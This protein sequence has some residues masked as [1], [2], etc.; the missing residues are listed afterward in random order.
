MVIDFSWCSTYDTTVN[1][2]ND[3]YTDHITSDIATSR[4]TLTDMQ[5]IIST[6]MTSDI[7]IK[8]TTGRRSIH[9]TDTN[10]TRNTITLIHTP[11]FTHSEYINTTQTQIITL[12]SDHSGDPMSRRSTPS[13]IPVQSIKNTTGYYF[14]VVL[15]IP[16]FIFVHAIFI[17]QRNRQRK[18]I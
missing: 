10:K 14:I 9:K 11:G 12:I 8:F 6:T 1:V 15:V 2:T 7:D 18:T 16:V 3:R 5:Q 13:V 17:V 4:I